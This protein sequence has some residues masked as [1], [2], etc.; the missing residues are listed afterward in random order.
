MP[1]S[2][3]KQLH[4]QVSVCES[5]IFNKTVYIFKRMEIAEYIYKGVYKTSYKN[6]PGNT[7]PVLTKSGKR[8][9]NP[10]RHILTPR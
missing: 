10:P 6:L 3:S 4:V 8:E 7:P 9:D 1:N 5:I 2:W